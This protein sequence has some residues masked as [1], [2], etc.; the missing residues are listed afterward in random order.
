M[1]TATGIPAG[2]RPGIVLKP[3]YRARPFPGRCAPSHH[4]APPGLVAGLRARVFTRKKPALRRASV[5][6]SGSHA[7]AY[8]QPEVEGDFTPA[9]FR[10]RVPQESPACLP[11]GAAEMV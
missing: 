3:F 4:N 9:W 1:E 2:H 8:Q 6:A 7:A 10:L 11:V 5:N